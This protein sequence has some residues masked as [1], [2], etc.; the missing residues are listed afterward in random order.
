MGGGRFVLDPL[1]CSIRTVVKEYT[2]PSKAMRR[3][4]M[5]AALVVRFRAED[6]GTLGEVV[7]SLGWGVG[8]MSETIPLGS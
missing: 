3:P 4:V 2:T 8:K 6:V 7:E 5:N 1:R